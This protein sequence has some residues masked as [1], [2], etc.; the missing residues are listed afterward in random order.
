MERI[1]EKNQ[2]NVLLSWKKTL[3][4]HVIDLYNIYNCMVN[5]KLHTNLTD[6]VRQGIYDLCHNSMLLLQRNKKLTICGL[7]ISK[8]DVNDPK[9]STNVM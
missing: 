7:F 1:G 9:K 6:I 2:G 5:G 4:H 3:A 8:N